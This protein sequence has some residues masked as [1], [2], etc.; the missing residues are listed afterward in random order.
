LRWVKASQA[1]VGLLWF[2]ILIDPLG[3]INLQI[4]VFLLGFEESGPEGRIWVLLLDDEKQMEASFSP[5]RGSFINLFEEFEGEG[6][7]LCITCSG[8]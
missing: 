3:P 7:F 2:L 6:V 5:F 4:L 1:L 8:K